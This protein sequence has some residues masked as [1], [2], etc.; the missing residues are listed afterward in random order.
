MIVDAMTE[1]HLLRGLQMLVPEEP[2]IRGH[3]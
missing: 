3:G 1:E 2:N